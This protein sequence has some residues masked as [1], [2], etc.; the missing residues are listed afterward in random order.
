MAGV[1]PVN[2]IATVYEPTD[3]TFSTYNELQADFDF[4][5][6]VTDPC[7]TTVMGAPTTYDMST[8][9]FGELDE[10]YMDEGTDTVS[11]LLGD[12]GGL[13]YCGSRF[14]TI[15]S[16]SPSTPVYTEFLTID[17]SSGQIIAQTSD[18]SHVGTYTITIENCLV[19]WPLRCG[20]DTFELVID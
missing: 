12:R 2:V 14:F 18:Q 13:T 11:E 20:Q 15:L 4:S 3:H 8:S 10:T 6:T 1:Y 19:D 17:T 16:V 9:V 5:I 7:E